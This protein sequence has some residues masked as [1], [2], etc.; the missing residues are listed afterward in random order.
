M[1]RTIDSH[2]AGESTRLVTRGL[3]EL[4]GETMAE[5]MADAQSR[6]PWVPGAVLLEP[7]GHK[8]LYGAIL[9]Q[10]CNPKADFGVVFM[11]NRG[12]EPMCGHGLIGVVTSLVETGLAPASEPETSLIADTPA[13]LIRV[14]A[15]VQLGHVRQVA[16]E[17][18][19]SFALALD[20]EL[21]MDEGDSLIVDVAFGGNFFVL[22][23]SRQIGLDLVIEN[24]PRLTELGM[25]I[26]AAANDQFPVCH[27]Q[28]PYL[29][30]ITDLRFYH[31]LGDHIH[32][33][34]SVVVLGDHMLD[35]SPCGTGTCAELA[36]H[37]ARGSVGLGE[38]FV[39]EG[40]LGT[41]FLGR[42]LRE[43]EISPGPFPY[44][45]IVPYLEG[46]AFLTGYHQ[47]VFYEDDPFKDGFLLA[48]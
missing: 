24:G 7:R 1:I 40:I 9:T 42:V 17:N 4:I 10:P 23:H 44:P 47:F 20:V 41:R 13:G 36:T 15:N 19:A 38:P 34:R 6:L 21:E 29:D 26:L 5:K 8:D 35:R 28:M 39:A 43:F 33:S 14:R 45:V 2:T 22:I 12:Y 32:G 31:E 3:P 46:Q 11:N 30:R 25:R 48:A 16:F 18:V 37:Y 27:P